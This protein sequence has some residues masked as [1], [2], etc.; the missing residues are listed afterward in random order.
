ME[1]NE[2]EKDKNYLSNIL[3]A[4][5]EKAQK[6]AKTTIEEVKKSIKLL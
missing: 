5:A 2:L 3:S 1:R 6:V 4:G